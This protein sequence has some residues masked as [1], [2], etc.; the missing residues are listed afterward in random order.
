MGKGKMLLAAALLLLL[1]LP[2]RGEERAPDGEM[3]ALLI[4]CDYFVSQEDTW[5]AADNNLQLL[6][7]TLLSDQRGYRLIRSLSGNVSSVQAFEEAVRSAFWGA[8]EEDTSLLYIST[9]GVFDEGASNASA[10]LLLSDGEREERLEAPRLQAILDDVPGQKILILDACNSGAFIGKGLSGGAYKVYFTG[11]DYKVLCSAGGS[12]ASWYW[13][14]T[15]AAQLSGASYFATVLADALG[16]RG[17]HAADSNLDGLITL[18]EAYH[19]LWDN[20]AASMPQVYP[21]NDDQF[22]LYAY[23]PLVHNQ[24]EKAIT[25]ISFEDTLLTAGESEIHFSF[26]VH[27]QVELYYQIVYHENG[28]WQFGI[29]QHFLDGEQLDG[30]VLPGRKQRTLSL[31]T[32]DGDAY[33]YAMIQLITIEEGVPRFQGARLL[34]VQP[35]ADPLSLSLTTGPAFVPLLGQELCIM[36]HHDMP[37]G[38]TVNILDGEGKTVRRLSYARPSRPQQLSP[39]GTTFYWD[40]KADNG[41]LAPPGEY[42]AQ[43]RVRL[44][45]KNHIRESDAFLLLAHE[46]KIE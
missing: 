34:C 42:R 10:A 37:C 9:H 12:E 11:P 20:Y 41:E 5:P 36:I 45:G 6:A 15:N 27:R 25:D 28:S 13:H 3:R 23:D 39:T 30:T 35:A 14:G 24:P 22:V 38:L 8:Q 18:D 32:G 29:A 1:A 2:A 46:E 31:D 40:G 7:D 26:T 4:G 33:G 43:V 21:E 16:P 17:D 19:F 44:G